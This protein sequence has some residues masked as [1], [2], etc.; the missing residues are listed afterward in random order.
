[1]RFSTLAIEEYFDDCKSDVDIFTE[2]R[3]LDRTLSQEKIDKINRHREE[4][5]KTI[6]QLRRVNLRCIRSEEPNQAIETLVVFGCGLNNDGTLLILPGIVP[7][8]T[9]LTKFETF[10]LIS[11]PPELA[12]YCFA[13]PIVHQIFQL[14]ANFF[15]L[16]K[17][18]KQEIVCFQCKQKFD[19]CPFYCQQCSLYKGF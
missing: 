7:E 3:L 4:V 15:A 13:A 8:Q 11:S 19:G 14:A 9:D 5:F 2:T 6:E 18:K 1:M 12:K 16:L 17:D 10:V